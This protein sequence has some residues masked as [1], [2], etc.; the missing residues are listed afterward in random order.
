MIR[1]EVL[2]RCPHS[3]LVCLA[4]DEDQQLLKG[5]LERVRLAPFHPLTGAATRR[6]PIQ[7]WAL[8]AVWYIRAVISARPCASSHL[9][10]EGLRNCSLQFGMNSTLGHPFLHKIP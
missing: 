3:G 8:S 4:V 7:C 6:A 10:I 5:F 1:A 9:C 2:R